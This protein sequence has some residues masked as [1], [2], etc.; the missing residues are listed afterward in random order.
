MPHSFYNFLHLVGIFLVLFS[1]GAIVLHTFNGGT[2]NY[3]ARKWIAILHGTGLL[4][5]FVAGFGLIARL[6]LVGQGVWPNWILIKLGV[7]ITLGLMPILLYRK[8][9]LSVLWGVLT[10]LLASLAA[11]VAINKPFLPLS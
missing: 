3:S 1:L 11:W 5:I 7:W 6:G 4:I 8:P 2:K 10:I 9:K